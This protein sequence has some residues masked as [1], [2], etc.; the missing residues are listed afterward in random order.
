MRYRGNKKVS[1]QRRCQR[2]R[3]PQQDP[4]QNQYA[5]LPLGGGGGHNFKILPIKLHVFSRKY[6]C[7]SLKFLHEISYFSPK[8]F[9]FA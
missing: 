4:H 9:N 6:V 8:F 2:R 3:R 7:F 1:R 5:P